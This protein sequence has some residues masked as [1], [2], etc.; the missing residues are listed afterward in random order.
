MTTTYCYKHVL[1][2]QRSNGKFYARTP[3]MNLA[4]IGSLAEIKNILDS[5]PEHLPTKTSEYQCSSSE[6]PPSSSSPPP[7]TSPGVGVWNCYTKGEGYT[8]E[9]STPDRTT[10]RKRPGCGMVVTHTTV[11]VPDGGGTITFTADINMTLWANPI[12]VEIMSG[13]SV[14][15]GSGERVI[16][17]TRGT[18]ATKIYKIDVSKY[19]GKNIAIVVSSS[20][21]TR[22][23]KVGDHNFNLVIRDFSF[24]E[25]APDVT[26]TE[27]EKRNPET[28]WDGSTIHK[29]VCRDNRWVP[30]GET[31]PTRPPTPTPPTTPTPVISFE[32]IPNNVTGGNKVTIRGTWDF[33]GLPNRE[34]VAI[35]KNYPKWYCIYQRSGVGNTGSFEFEYTTPIV[36]RDI[37]THITGIIQDTSYNIV[38]Q[39]KVSLIIK[40]LRVCTEGEKRNPETCWDGTKILREVCRDNRWVPTGQAC[41]PRVC[42]EGE[43]RNPETCWDGTKIHKEVCSGNRWVPTGETCPARPPAPPTPTPPTTPPAPPTPTPHGEPSTI[44][45]PE[46]IP[47]IKPPR[48]P[49]LVKELK[50]LPLL[51]GWVIRDAD[52]N[53]VAGKEPDTIEFQEIIPGIKPPRVPQLVPELEKLPLLPGW[54]IRDPEETWSHTES[55]CRQ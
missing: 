21:Y 7:V 50:N 19:A 3:S 32:I 20:D 17:I 25:N 24:I 27:G 44:E 39:S 35:Y 52:G 9:S 49:L 45:A 33:K 48:V 6:T 40:P 22:Y 11:H 13:P 51:P 1:I 46:I 42:T 18:R 8:C 43:K 23:C 29:E 30:T 10:I 38:A 34:R 37:S 15:I 2:T 12:N 36:D 55:H 26:C 41:P 47:G 31:C 53:V 14:D 28:C 5:Y 16:Q 4:D 54:T